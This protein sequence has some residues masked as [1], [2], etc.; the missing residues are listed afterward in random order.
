MPAPRGGVF[1]FVSEEII[2]LKVI[3]DALMEII[4][5]CVQDGIYDIFKVN[6]ILSDYD[7][8]LSGM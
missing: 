1:F 2:P 7:Q 8:P 3:R 4:S 5:Y 6:A